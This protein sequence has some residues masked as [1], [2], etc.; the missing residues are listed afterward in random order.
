MA[1]GVETEDLGHP[2][3]G[4][5]GG[6]LVGEAGEVPLLEG[7]EVEAADTG[8]VL[9]RLEAQAGAL[10]GL[11]EFGSE[12]ERRIALPAHATT[13]GRPVAPCDDHDDPL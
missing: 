7:L 1:G 3:D 6:L 9:D 10:A 12:T 4:H 2:A 11:T 8:A 5:Q 13:A